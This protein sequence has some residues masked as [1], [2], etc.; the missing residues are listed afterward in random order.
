MNFL[1][2]LGGAAVGIANGLFG[3]GGGMV[4]VPIL[5]AGGRDAKR[6]HAAAIAVIL[7]AS[8]VSAAVYAFSGAITPA[9][10]L[11]VLLGV[12]A[13]GY[14]GAKLLSR[15]PERALTLLFA[16]VML[17]AGIRMAMP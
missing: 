12:L 5:K 6:A 17:A 14:L 1:R 10:L 8:L 16:A 11:P 7:P 15:L 3:G 2:I 13:G 4:A 9:V